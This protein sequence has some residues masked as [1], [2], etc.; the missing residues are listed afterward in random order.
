MSSI[1]LLTSSLVYTADT[2]ADLSGQG[3]LIR[4]FFQN[5]HSSVVERLACGKSFDD[6]CSWADSEEP[7]H[8][9]ARASKRKPKK[10]IFRKV[11]KANKVTDIVAQDVF[12]GNFCIGFVPDTVTNLHIVRSKQRYEVHTH[13]LP[14]MVEHV[15]L[16]EN[17]L[18]GT[19]DCRSFPDRLRTID[20]SVNQLSGTLSFCKLPATL[21]NAY[22]SRNNFAQKVLYYSALPKDIDSIHLFD[23]KIGEIHPLRKKDKGRNDVFQT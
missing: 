20:L 19:I 4:A 15:Y 21:R 11:C 17:A 1:A 10:K 5:I 12:F 8:V 6:F 18:F 22:F 14:Q 16:R 13:L 23:L 2:D 3:P 9:S 7:Y